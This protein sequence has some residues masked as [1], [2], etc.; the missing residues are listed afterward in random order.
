M[1]QYRF[2]HDKICFNWLIKVKIDYI[3]EENRSNMLN[4]FEIGPNRLKQV[5]IGLNWSKEVKIF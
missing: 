1:D 2:K 5:K 4:Q 3:E